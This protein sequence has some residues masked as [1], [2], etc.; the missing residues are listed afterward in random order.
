M[1]GGQV[2]RLKLDLVEIGFVKVKLDLPILKCF[3]D[4]YRF[5]AYGLIK[6]DKVN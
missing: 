4:G 3:K 1:L 2:V 6:F 5:L